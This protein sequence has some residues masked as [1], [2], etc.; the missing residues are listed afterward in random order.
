MNEVDDLVQ[1]PTFGETVGVTAELFALRPVRAG[2]IIAFADVRILV[3]GVE[4]VVN[5]VQVSRAR[6]T[7]GREAT[8]VTV[9]TYRDE[10]GRWVAAIELP[11]ELRKPLGDT[12][13]E[14][15]VERGLCRRS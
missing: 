10:G 4:F 8:S 15:C 13:L 2:R 14:A 11:D 7:S 9:P 5:G 12:V 6:D 3:A 1:Q